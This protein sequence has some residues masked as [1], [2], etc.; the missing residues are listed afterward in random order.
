MCFLSTTFPN[1]PARPPPYTFWPVPKITKA[2]G[3]AL[4]ADTQVGPVNLFLHSLFSQVDVSLNERL[5]S[6]S[7][8]GYPYRAM[9]ESLLNY[10]EKAKTS[11]LSMAMF[12][13]DT[14]GKMNVVNLLAEDDE[15]NLG[16]KACYEFTKEKIGRASCRERV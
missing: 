4:D 10:A 1:A 9:I 6:A 12:Y 3:I 15:A 16:L 5:I 13:K 14:G 8:N 7:T 2:N 11:Q